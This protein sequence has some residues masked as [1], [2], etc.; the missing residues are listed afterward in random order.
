[1][2]TLYLFALIILISCS[3]NDKT[4]DLTVPEKPFVIYSKMFVFRDKNYCQ[5]RYY[6]KNGNNYY[7][8]DLTNAYHVGDTLK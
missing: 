2:K 8:S 1:M 5:Y 3:C 4:S 7:F 6:D